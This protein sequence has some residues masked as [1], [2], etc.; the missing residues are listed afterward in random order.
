M[1]GSA[2][3]TAP[4]DMAAWSWAPPRWRTSEPY[5]GLLQRG[6]RVVH[7]LALEDR[8]EH[9]DAGGDADLAE[10]VVGTR[11]HAAALRLDDR[12]GTRGQDRIDDAD[13]EA[14]PR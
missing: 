2:P 9:G 12:D 8:A 14:A 5:G 3:R 11:R 7:D 6:G 13:A 1:A 4:A 10:G